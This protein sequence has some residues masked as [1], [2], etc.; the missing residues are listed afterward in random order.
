[1]SKCGPNIYEVS[2]RNCSLGGSLLPK[3]KASSGERN[4][5]VRSWRKRE[6]GGNGSNQEMLHG[7]LIQQR[8]LC[9]MKLAILRF[10]LLHHLL[11]LVHRYCRPPQRDELIWLCHENARWSF[12]CMLNCLLTDQPSMILNM[13]V[14]AH[15]NQPNVERNWIHSR[16]K[17]NLIEISAVSTRHSAPTCL[18]DKC[19]AQLSSRQ[20]QKFNKL[21]EHSSSVFGLGRNLNW[22][23]LRP[24]QRSTAALI[25]SLL[26]VLLLLVLPREI[27]LVMDKFFF[28]T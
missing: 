2:S 22:P 20:S 27:D 5:K 11:L 14:L 19:V 25:I 17:W 9:E 21:R 10:P 7:H 8:D 6:S 12:R 18:L 26:L 23:G 16:V 15:D 4:T 28:K 13:T 24:L 3:E 1:M